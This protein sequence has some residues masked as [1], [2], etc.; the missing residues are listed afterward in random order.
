MCVCSM[1]HE[2]VCSQ[3]TCQP[4]GSHQLMESNI[5]KR[6]SNQYMATKMAS[7]SIVFNWR[8]GHSINLKL[9]K[10]QNCVVSNI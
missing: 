5:A 8:V 10:Q 6:N 3:Q 9:K 1:E 4:K 2:T 7:V